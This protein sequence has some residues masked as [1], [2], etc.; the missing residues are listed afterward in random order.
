M[1]DNRFYDR[2]ALAARE[3]LD[4]KRTRPPGRARALK[5]LNDANP[6]S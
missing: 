1:I 4:Q 3:V 5:L 6:D 2:P